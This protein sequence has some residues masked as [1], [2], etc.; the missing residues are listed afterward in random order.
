[1]SAMQ[2]QRYK[3]KS[4]V[5]SDRI[6]C[7][8]AMFCRKQIDC[9]GFEVSMSTEFVYNCVLYSALGD[10]LVQSSDIEA[11]FEASVVAPSAYDLPIDHSVSFDLFDLSDNLLSDF[12]FRKDCDSDYCCTEICKNDPV[13]AVSVFSPSSNRSQCFHK[14]HS[15][16]MSISISKNNSQYSDKAVTMSVFTE[17]LHDVDFKL[18]GF[19]F[20]DSIVTSSAY[21]AV[22]CLELCA[23]D[24]RCDV[25][26][27]V[28]KG[29]FSCHFHNETT[30]QTSAQYFNPTAVVLFPT[31]AYKMKATQVAI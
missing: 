4:P 11:D 17:K 20:P 6:R 23:A 9:K 19:E 21:S 16:N 10:S 3:I 2:S 8:C 26:S 12:N 31:I 5:S 13:C 1:M 18:T 22:L 27:W 14:T 25:A 28:G 29:S 30:F 24:A 7:M 15:T